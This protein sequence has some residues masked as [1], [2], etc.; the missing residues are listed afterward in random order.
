[1]R[2]AIALALSLGFVVHVGATATYDYKPGQFLVID[3]GTSPNKKF[4]MLKV[5]AS[6]CLTIKVAS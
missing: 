4:S 3:G 2:A 5:N 6:F 1:M